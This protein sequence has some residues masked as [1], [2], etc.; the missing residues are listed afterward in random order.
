MRQHASAYVRI[1]QHTSTDPRPS[2]PRAPP[3]SPARRCQYSYFV[4]AKQV[5][6]QVKYLAGCDDPTQPKHSM[7]TKLWSPPST[8]PIYIKLLEGFSRLP[9]P[10]YVSKR[11]HTSAYV[12]IR[13]HTSAYVSI[14][15]QWSAYVSIR[16]HTSAYISIRQHTSAYVS[17][18][19]GTSAYVSLRQHTTHTRVLTHPASSSSPPPSPCAALVTCSWHGF[20]I[21]SV[22]ILQ[23][24]THTFAYVSIRQHMSAYV[25][26]CQHMSA[27]VSMWVPDRECTRYLILL[28][29]L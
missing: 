27:Y 13:Q 1:H 6:Q 19:Q 29:L 3:S 10:A 14:R 16:Q 8:Y 15:Q 21:E 12:S 28:V 24:V 11:R 2:A 4:L 23:C 20:P 18:R 26:I 5:N 9:S 22:P 25:S 7:C 17:I